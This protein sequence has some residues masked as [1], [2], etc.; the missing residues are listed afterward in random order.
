MLPLFEAGGPG[1]D[2]AA[3]G[4]RGSFLETGGRV[5]HIRHFQMYRMRAAAV[6]KN[7]AQFIGSFGREGDPF[8]TILASK[9]APFAFWYEDDP[10]GG[11]VRYLTERE[12]ERLMGLPN[13][14]TE[15]GAAGERISP[16]QRYMALGNSIALPCASFI[17]EGI[18]NSV[19]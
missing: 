4:D 14:W 5:P 8:T 15:F 16:A 19:S 11:C 3:P 2:P 18:R 12:T 7:Q 9:N 13:G 1:G 10:A 17:M 6:N